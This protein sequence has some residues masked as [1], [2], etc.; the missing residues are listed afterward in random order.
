MKAGRLRS[1]QTYFPR[2]NLASEN[3]QEKYCN[4]AYWHTNVCSM[5]T[6]KWLQHVDQQMIAACWQTNDC[7]ML[8]CFTPTEVLASRRNTTTF[9]LLLLTRKVRKVWQ[10]FM[11]IDDPDFLSSRLVLLLAIAGKNDDSNSLTWV[12]GYQSKN[13]YVMPNIYRWTG[14]KIL[15]SLRTVVC[16]E[17]KWQNFSSDCD[18]NKF[19]Q[20]ILEQSIQ[21]LLRLVIKMIAI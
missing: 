4:A 17:L 20:F 6:N 15:W 3:L 5:L 12:D 9:K 21:V 1:R 8:T 10:G 13:V 19:W 2:S 16:V 7:S 11:Y 18:L 14:S